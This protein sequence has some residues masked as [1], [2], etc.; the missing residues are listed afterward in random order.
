MDGYKRSSVCAVA[1]ASLYTL[2]LKGVKLAQRAL[3]HK[4]LLSDGSASRKSTFFG[5]FF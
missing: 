4:T 2:A 3:H 1:V 5:G